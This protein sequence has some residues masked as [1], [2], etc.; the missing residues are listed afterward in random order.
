MADVRVLMVLVSVFVLKMDLCLP[1]QR[2]TLHLLGFLG[3][4]C[5]N[6]MLSERSLRLTCSFTSTMF[7]EAIGLII[8]SSKHDGRLLLLSWRAMLCKVGEVGRTDD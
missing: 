2:R 4:L 6:G 1:S 8:F 7:G 3:P 5:S